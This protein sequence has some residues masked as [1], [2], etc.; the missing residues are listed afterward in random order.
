MYPRGSL[1]LLMPQVVHKCRRIHPHERNHSAKVQALRAN[2]VRA[3]TQP[4]GEELQ[5]PR[6][7][8]R[9]S[10]HRNNVV[11]G[12]R[13]FGSIA[14]KNDLGSALPRPMP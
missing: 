9:K 14:P 6:A 1:A 5:Q 2:L 13:R 3:A 4:V 12:I 8:Q 7:H 11:R 10:A